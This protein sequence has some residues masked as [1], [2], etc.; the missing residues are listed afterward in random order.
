MSMI[1]GLFQVFPQLFGKRCRRMHPD[2]GRLRNISW[3]LLETGAPQM[4]DWDVAKWSVKAVSLQGNETWNDG[5]NE[6]RSWFFSGWRVHGS[7]NKTAG[8]VRPLGRLWELPSGGLSRA[9][10][11]LSVRLQ[12]CFQRVNRD[13]PRA[14]ASCTIECYAN[15]PSGAPDSNPPQ[16]SNSA[17][18]NFGTSPHM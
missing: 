10:N 8:L 4:W 5:S 16:S 9:G 18:R 6:P 7:E 15:T 1:R 2:K 17:R 11:M 3:G 14:N 13:F 12:S